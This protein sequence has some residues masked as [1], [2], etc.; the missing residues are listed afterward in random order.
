MHEYTVVIFH[1]YL[2]EFRFVQKSCELI[3]IDEKIVE[4]F[5][6]LEFAQIGEDGEVFCGHLVIFDHIDAHPLLDMS[7]IF[8]P[9]YDF[10]AP[11]SRLF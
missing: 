10:T 5:C 3:V 11:V 2:F 7:P 6:L 8:R 4:L 1:Q 9:V